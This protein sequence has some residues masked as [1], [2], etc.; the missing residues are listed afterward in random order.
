MI[1]TIGDTVYVE[2]F[3]FDTGMNYVKKYELRAITADH[4]ELEHI[5]TL[6]KNGAEPGHGS[7][8]QEPLKMLKWISRP[9]DERLKEHS[10]QAKWLC[11]RIIQGK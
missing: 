10:E 9:I 1:P 2:G 6:T 4:I 7:I 3:V 8:V 11:K 5:S